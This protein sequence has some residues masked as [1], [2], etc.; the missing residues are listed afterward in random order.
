MKMQSRILTDSNGLVALSVSP[1]QDDHVA[2]QRTL[3][4]AAAALFEADCPLSAQALLRK[5]PIG[6]VICERDLRRGT[7]VDVLKVLQVVVDQPPL[8]VTSRFAD[9]E[10]W[11]T[12]LNRGAYDV[13][14]KPFDEQELNRTVNLAWLRWYHRNDLPT[15]ATKVMTIAS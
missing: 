10:L 13:L 2:L 12:A 6:V 4:P 8:I 1:S 5:H 7:W 9:D 14:A 3:N 11:S 15:R